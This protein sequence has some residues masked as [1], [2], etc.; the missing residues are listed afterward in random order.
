MSPPKGNYQKSESLKTSPQHIARQ[1]D[2]SKIKAKNLAI[3]MS[4]SRADAS[5]QAV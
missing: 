3:A 4:S 1:K 5:M 2:L